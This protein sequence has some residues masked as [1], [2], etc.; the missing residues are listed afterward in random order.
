[1]KEL[2]LHKSFFLFFFCVDVITFC[3]YKNVSILL[4]L[5]NF[6]VFFFLIFDTSLFVWWKSLKIEY[7]ISHKL[8]QYQFKNKIHGQVL[9]M[10]I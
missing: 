8:L 9:F 4:K 3:G 6:L 2:F 1:M 5:K 7:K 10:D